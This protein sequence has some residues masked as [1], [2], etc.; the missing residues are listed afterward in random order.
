M[1]RTDTD[2][3]R[4]PGRNPRTGYSIDGIETNGNADGVGKQ[5]RKRDNGSSSFE[6]PKHAPVSFPSKVWELER[7]F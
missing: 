6:L 1:S 5:S 4:P 7:I 2:G 3:Q